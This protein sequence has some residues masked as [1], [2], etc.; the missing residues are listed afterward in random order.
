MFK[1]LK[2][3][4]SSFKQVRFVVIV[5]LITCAG[6]TG[7]S[8][9]SAYNF[10]EAQRQKIYVLDQ[11]KSLMLA[12]AQDLSTNRPVEARAHVCMFHELFFTIAPDKQAIE[13]NIRRALFLADRSVYN[14]YKDLEAK[15]YY[16]RIISANINQK[17]NIDSVVCDFNHYPYAVTTYAK[18]LIVRETSVTERNLVT[19]CNLLNTVRT[20]NSPFAYMIERFEIIN[21][22]DV[23][24]IK[25]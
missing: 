13:G 7:Y 6:I 2:N 17:I 23:K 5:F 12:L 15:G 21:N 11:G 16:N 4:D 24:T 8:V 1:S 25:R 18:Q 14:C 22:E 10:A 19:R 3:I 9:Y 20:D